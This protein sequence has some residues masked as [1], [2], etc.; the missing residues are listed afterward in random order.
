M[1]YVLLPREAAYNFPSDECDILLGHTEA[2]DG[3]G[4]VSILGGGGF[5]VLVLHPWPF[6]DP[7]P[8][9]LDTDEIK[10]HALRSACSP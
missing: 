9:T 6:S 4:V 5:P 7:E 1:R 3:Q 2:G 8:R 10:R